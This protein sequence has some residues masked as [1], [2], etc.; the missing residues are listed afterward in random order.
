MN[1][2]RVPGRTTPAFGFSYVER[3]LKDCLRRRQFGA[4]EKSK[5][6]MFFEQWEPQ[7]TCTY[8]GRT[9]VSRWDHVVPVMR[10]GATVLG[11]MVLACSTCDDSK[12]QRDFDEW[13]L[14]GVPK[15]PLSRGIANI[16]RRI[17]H[18]KSYIELY[19]Y[20]SEP[21]ENR[22]SGVELERLQAVRE[23]LATLRQEVDSLV[24]D[25]RG[26]TGYQ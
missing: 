7:P 20:R 9:E 11:N 25:F 3:S 17:E 15:S 26:R 12:S 24:D 13:M 10:D 6:V 1:L 16:S 8:C 23:R 4:D 19:T 14:S 18:I 22:L 2:P 5:A 21:V